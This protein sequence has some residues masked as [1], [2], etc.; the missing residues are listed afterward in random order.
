MKVKIV[1]GGSS[2]LTRVFN[3]E[4]GDELLYVTKIE[5]DPIGVQ[6]D[7]VTSRV[8]LVNLPIEIT[9]EAEIEHQQTLVYDPNNADSIAQAEQILHDAA[10]AL[11]RKPAS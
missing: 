4:T 1:S 10:V 7:V 8:T 6:N 2:R 3:A 5:I 9:C 11:D